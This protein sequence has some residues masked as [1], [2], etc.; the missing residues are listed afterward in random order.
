MTDQNKPKRTRRTPEQMAA[1]REDGGRSRT[2]ER[3]PRQEIRQRIG[4]PLKLDVSLVLIELEKFLGKPVQAKWVRFSTLPYNQKIGWEVVNKDFGESV[5][6]YT[7]DGRLRDS[8]ENIQNSDGG[9]YTADVGNGE[10]NFLMYKDLEQYVAE[11]VKWSEDDAAR[12]MDS[13]QNSAEMGERASLGGD[14]KSYQPKQQVKIE[15]RSEY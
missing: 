10:V 5:N 6:K 1:A 11:D 2:T 15:K 4:K 12:P 13:I 9:A 3:A 14:V 7:P 8:A